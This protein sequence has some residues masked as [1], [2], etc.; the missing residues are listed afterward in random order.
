VVLIDWEGK[1]A[2][3]NFISDIT[4][5]KRV[6]EALLHASRLEATATLAGGIAHDFNNLMT[7]VLGN[8]QMLK[9]LEMVETALRD[10]A[11]IVITE[12]GINPTLFLGN[13]PV[14]VSSERS[15]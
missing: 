1:P 7:G 11:K 13:L 8:A 10:N 14:N 4:E 2:T 3:L 12:H 6:E 5:R 15:R 9:Q